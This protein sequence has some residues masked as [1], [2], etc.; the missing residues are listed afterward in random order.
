MNA[1]TFR[2][3]NGTSDAGNSMSLA[4]QAVVFVDGKP[5]VAIDLPPGNVL[6]GPVQVELSKFVS[7]GKHR[8]EIHR[9]TGSSRASLQMLADYYVPWTPSVA[10]SNLFQDA[11]VSDALQLYVHFDKQSAIVGEMV[12]CSVDA[13]RIGF[14]G[15]GMMLAEIGLPPGAEVDRSSLQRAM[16]A[17]GWDINEYNVLPDKLLVYLWPRARGT[18]FSFTFKPRFGVRALSAPSILY[19]YYNPEAQATVAPTPFVVQ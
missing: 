19:D 3:S 11:K 7:S 10:N 13:E 1:L 16:E 17:S 5:A 8:I 4:A 15:Y 12:Q 2:Q 18:K 14:R 6:S 9:P